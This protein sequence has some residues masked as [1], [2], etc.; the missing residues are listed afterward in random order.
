MKLSIHEVSNIKTT[1]RHYENC[2]GFTC[3]TLA[4]T[5]KVAYGSDETIVDEISL[6]VQ[7]GETL[8]S[9]TTDES[10]EEVK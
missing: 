7:K 1:T 2:S 5:S 6:F 9:L 8:A 3:V 4:V 10:V